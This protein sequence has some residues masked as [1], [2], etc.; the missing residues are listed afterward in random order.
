MGT[1]L[2]AA[3]SLLG[4]IA[5]ASLVIP[6]ARR[7]GGAAAVSGQFT[8]FGALWLALTAARAASGGILVDALFWAAVG[9]VALAVGIALLVGFV[10]PARPAS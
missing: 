6:L 9:V 10:R 8:G 3:V 4:V 2:A 5:V 7:P 1:V